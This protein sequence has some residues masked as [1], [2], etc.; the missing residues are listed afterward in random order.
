MLLRAGHRRWHDRPP[1]RESV[2][3]VN[4]CHS[5]GPPTKRA[6]PF[7]RNAA[8]ARSRPPRPVLSRSPGAPPHSPALSP[9]TYPPCNRAFPSQL[10]VHARNP[11]PRGATA[12]ATAHSRVSDGTPRGPR[13]RRWS[14]GLSDLR[15][16]YPHPPR[17]PPLAFVLGCP[18][19]SVR[20]HIRGKFK[21][22][23]SRHIRQVRCLQSISS[24]G[25]PCPRTV[26]QSRKKNHVHTQK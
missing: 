18:K 25:R 7:V 6:P 26:Q 13:R 20:T 12:A 21:R 23:I 15:L 3:H 5:P 14:S 22:A 2:R 8:L 1:T 9:P 24:T 10:R 4:H 16:R 17:G 11:R 19:K